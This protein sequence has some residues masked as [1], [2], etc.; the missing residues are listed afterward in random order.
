MTLRSG[1]EGIP[2]IVDSRQAQPEQDDG[3]PSLAEGAVALIFLGL[4]SLVGAG[5][6]RPA[7]Q[8]AAETTN[9]DRSRS[10]VWSA[11]VNRTRTL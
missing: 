4:L 9:P 6:V 2:T 3:D 5:A 8:V 1:N 10:S 11:I 7:P